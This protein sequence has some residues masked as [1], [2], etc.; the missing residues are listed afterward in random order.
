MVLT[1]MIQLSR[2]G[3]NFTYVFQYF[4]FISSD[5]SDLPDITDLDEYIDLSLY[6][7]TGLLLYILYST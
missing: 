4:N 5:C 6:A 7:L 1:G 2:F 3:I